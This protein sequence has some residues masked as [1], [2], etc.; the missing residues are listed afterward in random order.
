M[1]PIK[2]FWI[3]PNG[4]ERRWLR[5]FSLKLTCKAAGRNYCS[6]QTFLHDCPADQLWPDYKHVDPR[7]PMHCEHCQRAFGPVDDY[8]L[9]QRSIYKRPD[10]GES[11]PLT[12]VP[13]GACW[14]APWFT[15]QEYNKG[16]TGS[17]YN[18]GPDGRCLVVRCP[19]G[20]DWM[21]DSRCSNCTRIDDNE[22][23]CWVRHGRPEDGN[24]HV[25]KNGNTCSA[26][27]G[28]IQTKNWHGFLHAGFLHT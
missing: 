24:L 3:E 16:K 18:V 12:D 13:V 21:I 11:W 19:D 27:A 6:A 28:S 20:H 7:W 15:E 9:F 2:V 14:S 26:G 25:D 5:R 10:T 1:T 8:Q 23:F 22:H 17:G 4:L